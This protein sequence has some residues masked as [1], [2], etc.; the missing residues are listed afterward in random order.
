MSQKKNPKPKTFLIL[1]I[2]F[3]GFS[4]CTLKLT[5]HYSGTL[6]IAENLCVNFQEDSCFRETVKYLCK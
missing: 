1:S 6:K 2:L 4:A 3:S 5:F